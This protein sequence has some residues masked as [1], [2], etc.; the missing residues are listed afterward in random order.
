MQ[1]VKPAKFGKGE[2]EGLRLSWD[3]AKAYMDEHGLAGDKGVFVDKTQE[4]YVAN[5]G[6]G[7]ATFDL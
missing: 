2:E 4:E 1:H 5:L 3:D 7:P 6:L